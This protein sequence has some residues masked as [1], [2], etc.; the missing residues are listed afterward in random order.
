M[1]IAGL[2]SGKNSM[3]LRHLHHPQYIEPRMGFGL[4]QDP[5]SIHPFFSIL[6]SKLCKSIPQNGTSFL[7]CKYF[8]SHLLEALFV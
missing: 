1:P 4:L 6:F 2:S 7:I 5:G 3:L 8:P